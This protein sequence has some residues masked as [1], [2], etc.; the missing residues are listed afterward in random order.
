MLDDDITVNSEG[1]VTNVVETEERNRFFDEDGNQLIVHDV[2]TADYA[3]ADNPDFKERDRV[4]YPMSKTDTKSAL[5]KAGKADNWV[6]TAWKSYKDADFAYD[7]L[8]PIV[9]KD[10][11]ISLKEEYEEKGW[12]LPDNFGYFKFEG[13]NKIYNLYDA[14]N[15]MWGGWMK[16]NDYSLDTP[17]EGADW[18]SRLSGNGSDT[19]ADQAAIKNGY[20]Y[21]PKI[22]SKDDE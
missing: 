1:I 13:E 3:I 6:E 8:A 22:N 20:N 7:Y 17:L 12:Y 21:Y 14:G 9:A 5:N 11:N 10:Q 2:K 18:N 16:M 15:S 4:Y 19:K